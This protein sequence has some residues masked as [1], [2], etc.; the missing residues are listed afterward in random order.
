MQR[1]INNHIKEYQQQFS[2]QGRDFFTTGDLRQLFEHAKEETNCNEALFR[3]A[4]E[5]LSVGFMVGYKHAKREEAA[6]RKAAAKQ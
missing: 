6:K 4:S 1:N 3:L 2:S 5:A